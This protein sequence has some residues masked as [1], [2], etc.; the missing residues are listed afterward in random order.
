MALCHGNNRTRTQNSKRVRVYM[1]RT[2][3]SVLEYSLEYS[4]FYST[5]FIRAW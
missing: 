1:S 2:G 4:N 5:A 3:N